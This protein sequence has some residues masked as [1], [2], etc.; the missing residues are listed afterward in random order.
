MFEVHNK[1]ITV[2]HI[3]RS[4][5]SYFP[6]KITFF[7]MLDVKY[8]FKIFLKCFDDVF[9]CLPNENIIPITLND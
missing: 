8:K 9:I 3:C 5:I 4:L 6:N 2:E 1:T 7:K